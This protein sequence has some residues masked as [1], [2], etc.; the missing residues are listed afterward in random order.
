[1]GQASVHE[2]HTAG[3]MESFEAALYLFI[4]SSG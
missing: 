2:R 1:L 3:A 4:H